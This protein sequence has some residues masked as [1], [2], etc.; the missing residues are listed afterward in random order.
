MLK[1]RSDMLSMECQLAWFLNLA[2]IFTLNGRCDILGMLLIMRL[3]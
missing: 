1:K 2:K 3:Q